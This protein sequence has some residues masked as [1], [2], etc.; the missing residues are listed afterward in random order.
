MVQVGEAIAACDVDDGACRCVASGLME[1][2]GRKYVMDIVCVVAAHDGVRFGELEAHVP[3]AST[4]TLSARLDDL[5]EADILSREQYD[6]IPPRVE[7]AFTDDGA[8]L[9]DRFRPVAEWIL[10]RET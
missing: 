6:E 7:Y 3:A 9:A 5:V 1:L 4:S 8:E 10:E 2:L